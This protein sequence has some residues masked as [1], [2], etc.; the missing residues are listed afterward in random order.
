MAK[1]STDPVLQ[2]LIHAVN[3]S[4]QAEVPMT[5][6]VRGSVLTGGLVAEETYFAELVD[7][8][9]LMGALEPS[10]GLLGK[11]YANQVGDASGHFLHF[12][13]AANGAEG[14]WRINLDSIDGWV[15]RAAGKAADQD[16]KGPFKGLFAT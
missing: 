3:K 9:P 11:E 2:Q 12:R 6:S 16:E 10:S 5:I 4:R 13:A 8:S 1:R 7:T 15:L 14:L